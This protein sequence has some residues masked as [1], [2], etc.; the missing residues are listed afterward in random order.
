[1]PGVKQRP[2]STTGSSLIRRVDEAAAPA[3]L[4]DPT[5][6]QSHREIPGRAA[7]GTRTVDIDTYWTK[8]KLEQWLRACPS[9][10]VFIQ[11][12]PSEAA[13]D[14]SR[15]KPLLVYYDGFPF[16]IPKGQGVEVPLPI[17]EIVKQSQQKHRTAQ[18]A[19]IDLYTISARNPNGAFIDLDGGGDESA[20]EF[21]EE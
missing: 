14:L 12:D 21:G 2:T 1:M 7:D 20:T 4:P 16:P 3:V 13:E 9:Q 8:R 6:F 15:I 17:A 10:T 18:S 11:P 19:G 5:P